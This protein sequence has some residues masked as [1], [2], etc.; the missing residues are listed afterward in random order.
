MYHAICIILKQAS[1]IWHDGFCLVLKYASNNQICIMLPQFA[2][3]WSM[4][5]IV[6]IHAACVRC[7]IQQC[8]MLGKLPISLWWCTLLGFRAGLKCVAILL[9]IRGNVKLCIIIL[10]AI[11]EL[12][13]NMNKLMHSAYYW[14]MLISMPHNTEFCLLLVHVLSMYHNTAFCLFLEHTLS[15]Y[16]NTAFCLFLEHALSMYHY[17]AFCLL[18]EH[19]ISM[20]HNTAFCLLL[21]HA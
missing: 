18:L 1:N 13:L 2:C 5:Q 10:L 9:T 3:Y 20:Y 14:S 6:M 4:L 19:A 15:M 21:E 7:I 12:A 17:T 8:L 11:I 16:H